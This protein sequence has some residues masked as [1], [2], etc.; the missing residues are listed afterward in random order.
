M[1]D[2][3]ARYLVDAYYAIQDFRIQAGHQTRQA[4]V[5]EEPHEVIGWL[6]TNM[7]TLEGQIRRALGSYAEGKRPGRW[8]LAQHGIGPV[9][10]AGLLAH[11]DVRIATTPSKVWRFAGLDPTVKWEKGQKR[12]WNARLKV[13]CWKIGESFK[14]TSGSDA[15]FYGALY[16]ARKELEVARNEAGQFADTAAATLEAKK[17]RRDTN[18]KAAYERGQLPAGRLDLRAMRYA[19][20]LFLSHFWAVSTEDMTGKPAPRAWVLEH[21]G[22]V[23]E[24][25]PPGWPCE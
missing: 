13:L 16:R 2:R 19:T 20:K 9:I 25:R 5:A 4:S 22:H 21:G 8:A 24:M 23:D 14:K 10:T 18:A 3:E 6:H 12:P 11:I 15:S 7:D 17:F 1:T